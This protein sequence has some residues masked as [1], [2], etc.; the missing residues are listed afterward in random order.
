MW[1]AN[2]GM[3]WWMVFG[4]LFWLVALALLA[5]VFVALLRPARE[6]REPPG[7]PQRQDS[8]I[9]VVQRRYASGEITR[10][11]FARIREDLAS[12]SG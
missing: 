11:E 6:P 5:Y 7:E 4:G 9:E 12:D 1:H 2:D 3:G 8:P 10:E